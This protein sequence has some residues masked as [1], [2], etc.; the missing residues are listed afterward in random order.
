VRFGH[1]L[2][3][4]EFWIT[5]L[6]HM[7]VLSTPWRPPLVWWHSRIFCEYTLN[8]IFLLFWEPYIAPSITPEKTPKKYVVW[9]DPGSSNGMK[10]SD[11]PIWIWLN[12]GLIYFQLARGGGRPPHMQEVE[13]GEASLLT[14][15]AGGARSRMSSLWRAAAH[16]LGRMGPLGLAPYR[17]WMG[18]GPW[19]RRAREATVSR[20]W[21]WR[22][23]IGE[24][25]SCGNVRLQKNKDQ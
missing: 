13:L 17:P 12:G 21:R 6:P 25:E 3:N 15:A 20:T 18:S 10:A 7:S 2:A 19:L 22:R 1:E 5:K 4:S 24:K 9:I 14:G 8:I 16:D 23:E 11:L